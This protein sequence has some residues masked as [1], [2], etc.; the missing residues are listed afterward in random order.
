L[1]NDKNTEKDKR[2]V[3]AGISN[4]YVKPVNHNAAISLKNTA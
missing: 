2:L 3:F 1:F 4:Q